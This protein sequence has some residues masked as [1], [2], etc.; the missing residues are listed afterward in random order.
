MVKEVA[1][2]AIKLSIYPAKKE[3][4]GAVEAYLK[5]NNLEFLNKFSEERWTAFYNA[6]IHK[7]VSFF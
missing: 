4:C 1:K 2:L 5:K 6:N 3:M 7:H